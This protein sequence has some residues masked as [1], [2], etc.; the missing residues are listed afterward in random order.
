MMLGGLLWSLPKLSIC[1]TVSTSSSTTALYSATR[2]LAA[3][4]GL[5]GT[6]HLS[7]STC[8]QIEPECA[9]GH[10]GREARALAQL[11]DGDVK[12]GE[13]VL[14]VVVVGAREAKV[15][16]VVEVA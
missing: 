14:A 16:C 2:S 15:A 13:D 9:Y 4:P 12:G 10:E 7:V 3:A 5:P 1:V 11:L 6:C 8:R